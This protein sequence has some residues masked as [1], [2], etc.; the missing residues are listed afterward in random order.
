MAVYYADR[1]TKRQGIAFKETGQRIINIQLPVRDM[2]LWTDKKCS[3][4]LSSLLYWLTEDQWQFKF[5]QLKSHEIEANKYLFQLPV[6]KPSKTVLFS[7]GLD[8]LAGLCI[9]MDQNPNCSFVLFS[10]ITNKIIFSIQ[11]EI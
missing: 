10:G 2:E 8:S 6:K 3:E 4:E 5:V 7:G 9:L 11:K 1:R